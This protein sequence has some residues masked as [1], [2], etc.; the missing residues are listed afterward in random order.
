MQIRS[1]RISASISDAILADYGYS[2]DGDGDGHDDNTAHQR[3]KAP[4]PSFPG[5]LIRSVLAFFSLY[6]LGLARY[7]PADFLTLRHEVWHMDEDDYAA[8]FQ[9]RD[10]TTTTSEGDARGLDSKGDGGLVPVGDLGYSGSTF[11]T[12]PDGRYLVK[13]LPRR[14]EHRFFTHDLFGPYVAH[15]RRHPGSLLVRITD[16]PYT[17]RPTLGGI[18]GVAPTHHIVMENLLHGREQASDPDDWETYDLKPNDYFFPERDI[19]D[20]R[21]APQSVKDRLVDDFPGGGVLVDAAMKRQLLDVLD[22]DTQLL[23]DANAVDYSLFLVRSPGPAA[24]RSSTS[25][26]V[27][28]SAAATEDAWRAG[29]PSSNGQWAYRA[30][31]LDF[32]WAKHKFRAKAMSGLVSAFNLIADKGPMSITA[33]PAEYRTRFLSMVDNLVSA[34]G[35]RGDGSGLGDNGGPSS[36]WR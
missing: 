17:P 8:S 9:R 15:M 1:S 27:S 5:S 18:L 30:V 28:P 3:T 33:R 26:P 24:T 36:S 34:A 6:R 19:A 2:D 16:M 23:A 14:F 11:F 12:T 20:G 32:F 4:S 29:V 10:T 25:G 7:R 22:A 21:L 13:S 35:E 31:V